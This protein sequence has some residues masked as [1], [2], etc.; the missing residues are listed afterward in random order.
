ME[1]P[2][3][4]RAARNRWRSV[5]ADRTHGNRAGAIKKRPG[6]SDPRKS[7]A[8]LSYTE[9]VGKVRTVFDNSVLEAGPRAAQ[10][11]ERRAVGMCFASTC[12]HPPA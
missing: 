11:E 8:I 9:Y 5:P 4:G 2:V 1:R 12:R 6:S 7:R 3:K 10:A